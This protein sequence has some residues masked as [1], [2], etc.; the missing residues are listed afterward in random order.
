MNE[1][2]LNNIAELICG[3]GDNDPEYRSSSKLTSFFDK[4]GLSNF[5]H[6]GSTRQK[7][8]LEKLKECNR[9]QLAS[10]LKRLVTPIEYKGDKDK[11]H[12]AL[13]KLNEIVYIEG[14]KVKLE[15]VTPKFEK[16]VVDFSPNDKSRNEL[17]ISE[18]PCFLALGLEEGIGEI[19]RSRWEEVLKCVD[20]KAHL[21]AIILMGSLLEGLLLGVCQ[22]NP[23]VANKCPSAPK[24][25]KSGKV[26]NFSNWKLAEMIDVA[27]HVGWLGIDVKK[28]SHVLRDFRNLIHPYEQISTGS[29]PDEDT[30]NISWLVVQAAVNDLVIALEKKNT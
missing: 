6:D 26:K 3:N 1:S 22:K 29:F 19:L 20:A 16:I 28:F 24:D 11:I 25:N 14:F 13:I 18:V 8:V 27:Y 7:W 2:T 17:H 10:V 4:A 5:V 21:S 12:R 23:A 30:C 9:S 15:G